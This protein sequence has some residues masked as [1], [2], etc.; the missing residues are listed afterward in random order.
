M[1]DSGIED[2]ILVKEEV[3]D[4]VA[5]IL[6]RDTYL[7]YVSADLLKP[8]LKEIVSELA[9]KGRTRFVLNLENVGV[10]DSCGLAVLV[11]L[12]KHAEGVSGRLVLSN[13]SA[14]I[15]RL[16]ALTR[17]DKALEVYPSVEMAVGDG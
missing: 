7:N 4:D 9:A 1:P 8:R 2:R 6:L 17:L 13:L 11:S 12:K 10:V 15:Q 3:A 16:F 5:V 14:M